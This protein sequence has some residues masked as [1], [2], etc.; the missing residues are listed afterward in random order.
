[1]L[2]KKLTVLLAAVMMLLMAAIPAWAAAG[3]HLHGNGRAVGAA[4]L[5]PP[6]AATT[7]KPVEGKATTRI[8]NS[9]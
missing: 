8:S 5:S 2:R 3:G 4:T 9:S 6:T 7:L 1:V